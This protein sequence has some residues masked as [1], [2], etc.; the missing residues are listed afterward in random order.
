MPGARRRTHPK[1]QRSEWGAPGG[2]V[3]RGLLSRHEL[4][5]QARPQAPSGGRGPSVEPQ[6]QR[7]RERPAPPCHLPAQ[8]CLRG[9]CSLQP[10][11]P[12]PGKGPLS[13]LL[14]SG[15]WGRDVVA[16]RAF[17][18][19]GSP[20][21]HVLELW[22]SSPHLWAY[23]QPGSVLLA[24]GTGG[25]TCGHHPGGTQCAQ[26]SSSERALQTQQEWALCDYKSFFFYLKI[27]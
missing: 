27:I 7:V 5:S 14:S 15:H 25:H 16:W 22:L 11:A 17:L 20:G 23:A 3:G 24:C 10:P 8:L 12:D 6:M 4:R 26:R 9:R 1:P 19:Y 13:A 2:W 21:V 18:G